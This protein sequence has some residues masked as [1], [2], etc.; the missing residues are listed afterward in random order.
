MK[1][2]QIHRTN[3]A[4]YLGLFFDEHLNWT[5]HIQQI[6]CKANSVNAFLR[7]NL[8]SSDQE[9]VL[10]SNGTSYFRICSNCLVSSVHTQTVT[11][12]KLEMVQRR[13]AR[14]MT[15]SYSSWIS[16]SEILIYQLLKNIVKISNYL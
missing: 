14:F 16:V 2:Y 10:S 15:N 7:R 1:Q 8:F 13:A 12:H 5:N 6:I 9:N 11:I 4:T 3:N